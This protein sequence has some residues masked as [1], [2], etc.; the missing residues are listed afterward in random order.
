[1][2]AANFGRSS[3]TDLA[4]SSGSVEV[5]GAVHVLYGSAA[6]LTGAGSQIWSQASAG[7]KGTPE[8]E[9]TFGR[10]LAAANFNGSGPADLAVGNPQ[11]AVGGVTAAG[12]VHIF[13]GSRSR[14]TAV[15]DHLAS[16][17]GRDQGPG[18]GKGLLRLGTRRWPLRRPGRG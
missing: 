15:G 7:I 11:E 6:G 2:A 16:R 1:M 4:I 10:A 9:N 12:S 5:G 18:P 8:K 14:L 13:L 17:L 3:F